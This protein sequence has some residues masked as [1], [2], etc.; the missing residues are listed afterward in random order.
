VTRDTEQRINWDILFLTPFGKA[1]SPRLPQSLAGLCNQ[2]PPV[3]T[4]SA[5]LTDLEGNIVQSRSIKGPVSYRNRDGQFDALKSSIP[6]KA[7]H[8]YPL[9]LATT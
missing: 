1:W 2:C 6:F 7:R 4:R 9:I 3:R 5:R 8:L